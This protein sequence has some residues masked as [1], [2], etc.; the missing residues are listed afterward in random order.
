MEVQEVQEVQE[1]GHLHPLIASKGHTEVEAVNCF[2]SSAQDTGQVLGLAER[3]SG[4]WKQS[5]VD[6]ERRGE[7]EGNR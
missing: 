4:K 5:R 1:Y 6:R 7:R 2:L 3:N